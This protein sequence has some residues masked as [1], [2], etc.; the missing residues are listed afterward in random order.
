MA[1][2]YLQRYVDVIVVQK[3]DKLRVELNQILDF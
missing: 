3:L 2:L 1:E